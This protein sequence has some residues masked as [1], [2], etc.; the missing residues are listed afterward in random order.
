MGVKGFD[1]RKSVMDEGRTGI[2]FP[3]PPPNMAV[4]VGRPYASCYGVQVR[5]LPVAPL[6]RL[7]QQKAGTPVKVIGVPALIVWG[8][9]KIYRPKF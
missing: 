2:R 6:H 4:L 9:I 7:M 5:S 1:C 3:T 8:A